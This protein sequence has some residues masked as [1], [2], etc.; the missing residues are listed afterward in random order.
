MLDTYFLSH[1]NSHTIST[2]AQLDNL[3]LLPII[4]S[5]RGYSLIIKSG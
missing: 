3:K 1:R 5:D 2:D 4:I